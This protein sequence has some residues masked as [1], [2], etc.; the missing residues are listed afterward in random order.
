MK[1]QSIIEQLQDQVIHN[2]IDKE[3]LYSEC[4]KNGLDWYDDVL[5]PVGYNV[6]DRCG[7][8][9]DSEVDFFWVDG[10]EWE[11]NNPKDQA[12]LKKM[13]EEGID[14]CAICWDCAKE[15]RNG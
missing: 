4:K 12:M 2:R 6:C 8:Y 13:A 3:E 15:L 7:N 11:E 5:S 10:F 14:Y 1:N 9:G